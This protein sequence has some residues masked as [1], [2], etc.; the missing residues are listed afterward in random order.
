MVPAARALAAAISSALRGKAF[1]V[2][3]RIARIA[4]FRVV[5]NWGQSIPQVAFV[6]LQSADPGTKADYP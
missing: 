3:F 6:G 5:P 4:R 1:S 2:L